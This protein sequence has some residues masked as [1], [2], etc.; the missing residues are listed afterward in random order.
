MIGMSSVVWK[1]PEEKLILI[2]I[3]EFGTGSD[4]WPSPRK[5]GNGA[6]GRC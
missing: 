4:T 3:E 5:K 1:H 6:L 2:G